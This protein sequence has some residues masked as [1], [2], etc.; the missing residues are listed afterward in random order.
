MLCENPWGERMATKQGKHWQIYFWGSVAGLVVVLLVA[1]ITKLWVLTALPV[2]FLFGFFL[3]KGDLCGASA[4]SEVVLA[5]DTRKIVG[6][7]VLIVVSMLGFALFERLGLVQLN[8]KPMQW[9]NYIIGGV[10]FGVGMVLAGGCVSGCLFKTGTGN[11]NSM[12]ALVGIGL[13]A[14]IIIHGPLS[15]LH[16]AANAVKIT[17]ADGGPVTFSSVTGFPYWALALLISSI[18]FGLILFFHRK[19]EKG[20]PASPRTSDEPYLQRILTHSWKPWQAGLMIGL[21]AAPAYLS[22]AVSGRNYPLGVTH[23][24]LHAELLLTD[25]QHKY[26]YTNH[27]PE[28]VQPSVE[29][30]QPVQQPRP[31]SGKKVVWWLVLVVGSLV[32][33]SWVSGRMSDQAKLLPKPPEQIVT[34]FFGGIMVGAGASFANGCVVGSIMSG[35]GLMSVGVLIFTASTILANWVTTRI[36]LMGGWSRNR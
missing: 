6:L 29:N 7:W 20:R 33:G 27:P 8:P 5:K 22:S 23:G 36:Y 26:V 12:A 31:G 35:I 30:D 4:F 19:R 1:F 18:T 10:V 16:R 2:G 34:A 32:V 24:V 25:T 13:G 15:G 28:V 21:L 9:I 3:Q 17:T 14:A 11:L